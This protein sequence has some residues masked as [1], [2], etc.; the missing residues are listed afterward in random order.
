MT[1][2]QA[3]TLSAIFFFQREHG[4]S[5]TIREIA[6]ETGSGSASNVHD[7]LVVLRG[8]GL[9]TWVEELPRTLVLTKAGRKAREVLAGTQKNAIM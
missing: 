4:Y 9:V 3:E 7:R 8:Y 5:P 6:G 1:V 2:K